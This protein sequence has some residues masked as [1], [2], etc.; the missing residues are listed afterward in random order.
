MATLAKNVWEP[1]PSGDD[2]GLLTIT[3]DA[4]EPT[5]DRLLITIPQS[6]HPLVLPLTAKLT[7]DTVETYVQLPALIWWNHYGSCVV[8]SP[9][10]FHATNVDPTTGDVTYD[11]VQPDLVV[12]AFNSVEGLKY[13]QLNE[14]IRTHVGV[15]LVN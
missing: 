9:K 13:G 1:I 6:D 10:I 12:V 11:F 14:P 4:S 15:N 5:C 7:I 2:I 8:E 3:A